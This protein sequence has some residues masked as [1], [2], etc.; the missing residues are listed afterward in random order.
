[1]RTRIFRRHLIGAL[2]IVAGL[3]GG[4]GYHVAGRASNL[5][6]GW[7]A[8]AVPAFKNDTTQYRIEQRLTESVIREFI[9][10]TK[11]HIIQDTDSADGVLHGEVLSIETTPVLF[12]AT[13]GQVTTMLVTVHA[14]VQLIDN[15]SH[16]A[17]YENDDMVFRS[18]YQ[19]STDVQSFFQEQSPALE[20]L[21]RDFAS[22]VVA[23]TLESF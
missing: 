21:S 12:N 23:D 11:Y 2:A 3:L 10:R 22:R 15:K 7:S 6:E 16:K 4:C 18:E 13:T 17:V 9:T 1:L 5:P 14:K 19:I 8:I 20:R